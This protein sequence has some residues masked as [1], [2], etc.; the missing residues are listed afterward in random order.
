M[1]AVDKNEFAVIQK[2]KLRTVGNLREFAKYVAIATILLTFFA[3]LLNLKSESFW[4]LAFWYC[5]ACVTSLLFCA[6]VYLL[7]DIAA[8]LILSRKG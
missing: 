6:I 4:T 3:V 2:Q 1:R 7:A 8:E 5:G